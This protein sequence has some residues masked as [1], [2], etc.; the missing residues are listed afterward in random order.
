MGLTATVDDYE[1]WI[2]RAKGV[3]AN[4]DFSRVDGR[5]K[6]VYEGWASASEEKR[7]KEKKEVSQFVSR[8]R[9]LLGAALKSQE[10]GVAALLEGNASTKFEVV[11]DWKDAV[12]KKVH[13]DPVAIDGKYDDH[14]FGFG[15]EFLLGK[16]TYTIVFFAAGMRVDGEYFIFT[17][18]K[19]FRKFKGEPPS[20]I[21]R[22]EPGE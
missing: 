17:I 11:G 21:Y 19:C 7:E 15:I 4:G 6:G 14:M 1:K 16:E 2:L 8:G 10:A 22:N 13:A 12:F 20:N 3:V 5:T 9:E 18:P